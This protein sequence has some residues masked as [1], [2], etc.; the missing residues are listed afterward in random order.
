MKDA[1]GAA[2]GTEG[3]TERAVQASLAADSSPACLRLLLVEDDAMV[4]DVVSGLLRA[5]GHHVDHA[6]HALAAFAATA[7]HAFDLALLDLDLPGMDGLSLARQLRVQGF[8]APMVALTARSDEAAVEHA[9]AAGFNRFVRKPVNGAMLS[10][11]L[12]ELLAE[13]TPSG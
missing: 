2:A 7:T 9:R 4:A 6:P 11:V 12:A 1:T 13:P 10:A 8:L 3:A 5:Q